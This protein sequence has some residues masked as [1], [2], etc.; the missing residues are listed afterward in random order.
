MVGVRLFLCLVFL[1]VAVNLGY[2]GGLGKLLRC[3]ENGG[4]G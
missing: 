4:N 3:G 1:S 2:L